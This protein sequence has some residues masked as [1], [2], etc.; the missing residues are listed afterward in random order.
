MTIKLQAATRLS[1]ART[2]F[3]ILEEWKKAAE[4]KGFKVKATTKNKTN[5][6]WQA[7][8]G[9][10]VKG[11]FNDFKPESGRSPGGEL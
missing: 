1:A 5:T 3:S 6:Y 4:A 9:G 7:L 2:S 8:L 11:F 10:E